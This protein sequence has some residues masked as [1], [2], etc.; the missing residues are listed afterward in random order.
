M[1]A[2]RVRVLRAKS[3]IFRIISV[4]L[5]GRKLKVEKIEATR[6]SLQI[7]S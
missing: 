3:T 7:V 2:K 6:N 5:K 4:V 1:L